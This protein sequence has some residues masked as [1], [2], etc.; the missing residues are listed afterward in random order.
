MTDMKTQGHAMIHVPVSDSW[1]L[2]SHRAQSIKGAKQW[3]FRGKSS[4]DED[5]CEWEPS[6]K[7]SKLFEE[8]WW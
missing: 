8:H 7:S 3:S 2:F 1:T 5:H 6:Q 4:W